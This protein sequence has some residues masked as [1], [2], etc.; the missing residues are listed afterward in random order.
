MIFFIFVILNLSNSFSCL[1]RKKEKKLCN[2]K[3]VVRL[4]SSKKLIFG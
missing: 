3:L 4:V 1:K 2:M